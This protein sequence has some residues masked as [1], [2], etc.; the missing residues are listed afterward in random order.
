MKHPPIPPNCKRFSIDADGVPCR[1]SKKPHAVYA[2]LYDFWGPGMALKK[3]FGDKLDGFAD[4][5]K[6]NVM[7]RSLKP[8]QRAWKV[9]NAADATKVSGILR[10]K[11]EYKGKTL[12]VVAS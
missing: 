3:T 8:G 12:T 1:R 6:H 2:A 5:Y 9:S 7:V 11:I 4:S 10:S